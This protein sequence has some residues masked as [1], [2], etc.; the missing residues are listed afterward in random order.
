MPSSNQVSVSA[1]DDLE[2][3]VDATP[4]GS[5]VNDNQVERRET[6][7]T[8][9]VCH[10]EYSELT[11]AHA[12]IVLAQAQS[13]AAR[14]EE[15]VMRNRLAILETQFETHALETLALATELETAR[16]QYIDLDK[17]YSAEQAKLS[18]LRA[19]ADRE[20]M[21]RLRLQKRIEELSETPKGF[22][23]KLF[24]NPSKS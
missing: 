6:V 7:P 21:E 17:R 16:Q 13:S 1:G 23:S 14:N 4:V 11:Q 12:A 9:A 10:L 15:S 2:I 24:S 8:G 18:E 22:W 3:I 5:E 19:S 20:H